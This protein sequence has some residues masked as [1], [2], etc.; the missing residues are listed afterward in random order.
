MIMGGKT[1]YVVLCEPQVSLAISHELVVLSE[2]S[3]SMEP[4]SFSK[5]KFKKGYISRWALYLVF[6][7]VLNLIVEII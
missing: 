4:N 3:E 5:V 6:K 7:E 2:M 1:L